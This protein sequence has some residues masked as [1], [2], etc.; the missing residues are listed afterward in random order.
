VPLALPPASVRIVPVPQSGVLESPTD[1][2]DTP[3]VLAAGHGRE[4]NALCQQVCADEGWTF[5]SANEADELWALVNTED[6]WVILLPTDVRGTPARALCAGIR[7]RSNG[8]RF[9]I[10]GFLELN[11]GAAYDDALRAG[12]DLCLRTSAG[13][14]ALRAQL[15][16]LIPIVA[17]ARQLRA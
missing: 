9:A 15:L 7:A 13:V 12:F 2:R 10:V 3:I 8:R 5:V 1:S 6:P 14:N 11:G 16:V 4:V 17:A